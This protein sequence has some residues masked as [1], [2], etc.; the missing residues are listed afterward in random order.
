MKTGPDALVTVENDSGSAK[1]VNG[2]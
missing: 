2:T 1:H